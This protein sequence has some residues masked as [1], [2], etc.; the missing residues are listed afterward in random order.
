MNIKNLNKIIHKFNLKIIH[1]HFVFKNF[2]FFFKD[3]NKNDLLNLKKKI[4]EL[5]DS[6][7]ELNFENKNLI[8]ECRKLQKE[9]IQAKKKEGLKE[10]DRKEKINFRILC[11]NWENDSIQ[12]S[13][14]LTKIIDNESLQNECIKN[15]IKFINLLIEALDSTDKKIYEVVIVIIA[16][17][18]QK[19]IV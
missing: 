6:K 9:L 10:E 11:L 4:Q 2:F 5:N 12:K 1:F 17:F 13:T 16:G 18:L 19:E 15:K 3:N 8:N 14:L 7:D